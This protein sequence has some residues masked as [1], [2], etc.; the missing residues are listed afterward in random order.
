MTGATRRLVLAATALMPPSRRDWGRAIAA[1]LDHA[2]SAGGRARLVLGAFS[3]ALLP[4][5]GLAGY[6]RA[7]GWAVR[8]AV[9]AYVPLGSLVSLANAL[10]R[11]GQGSARVTVPLVYVAVATM[12]AGALAR[13]A[14]VKPGR[15]VIAGI[16]AGLVLGGLIL[17]TLAAERAPVDLGVIV[18]LG[19]A[20]AAFAPIGA[21]LGRELAIVWTRVRGSGPGP[22]KRLG[23]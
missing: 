15:A 1:E 21:A 2:G 3:V 8:V 10:S 16:S 13:R 18:V 5:P 23:P 20:G 7:V 11:P 12:A 14:P 22:G 4:P 6:G 9:I 19:L 17:A